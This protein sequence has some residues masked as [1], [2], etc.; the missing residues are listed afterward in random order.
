M[1]SNPVSEILSKEVKTDRRN[2]EKFGLIPKSG[3]LYGE[4]VG[5]ISD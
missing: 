2:A 4:F 1:L 5:L 3:V